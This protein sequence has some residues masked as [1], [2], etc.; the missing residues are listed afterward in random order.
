MQH[1]PRRSAS[2]AWP[3]VNNF[4]DNWPAS[5]GRQCLDKCSGIAKDEGASDTLVV[6]ND[7]KE[8]L[9]LLAVKVDL[10]NIKVF[11]HQEL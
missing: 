2:A 6:I 3:G 1:N 7:L 9:A 10:T 5:R 4:F 8:A 11:I